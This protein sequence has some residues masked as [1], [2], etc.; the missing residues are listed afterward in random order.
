MKQFFLVLLIFISGIGLY[1]QDF[2]KVK[3]DSLFSG[4]DESQKG[5]GSISIFRNGN[6]VYQRSF[7]FSDIEKNIK[8]SSVTKYRIGS[9]SKSFT[10]VIIMQLIEKG[11]LSLD[12]RLGDFFPGLPNADKISI[13]NLLRHRSGLFD[14]TKS[15]DYHN[16]MTKP[17]TEPEL[18][19]II[20]ENGTV[21]E[22]NEKTQYSNTNYELLAFIAEKIEN[23][24][25]SEIIE[26]H[27]VKP[28][29]LKNTYYGNEIRPENNEALSYTKSDSWN[30]APETDLSLAVGSGA[31]VSNPYDINL[32]YDKLF[33]GEIVSKE[34]IYKM[35]MIVDNFGMGLMQT[36]FYNKKALG[37]N[38]SID[39][40]QTRA[41]YFSE[42]S[43][44]LTYMTN[45][46]DMNVEEI[47]FG[48]LS[49][50]FNKSYTIPNFLPDIDS[51]S[52][53]LDQYLGV[54]SNPD[55]PLEIAIT[56]KDG[57]LIAQASGQPSFPL[58]AYAL[59]KFK[60]D[61]VGLTMEFV[62]AKNKLIFRQ[63]GGIIEFKRKPEL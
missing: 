44:S 21:F 54:Y 19:E 63:Y 6:E 58:E 17:M 36:A 40:F 15:K 57:T 20:K 10:A 12:S 7:G 53:N 43:M 9:V 27:I 14:F 41:V 30:V 61:Q 3:M 33:K 24:N 55:F 32:F 2:N 1:A 8:T 47:V 16:W 23:K 45:A 46:V 28:S 51:I 48:A 35:R 59:H 50:Y 26:A 4:I 42:D 11:K 34:S 31:I 52:T 62:P 60:F 56:K 37:H 25:F 13:E 18:L 38:G 39:G 29:G 5:M 22:S 49:I